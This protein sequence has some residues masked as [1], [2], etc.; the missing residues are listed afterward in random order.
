MTGV[1]VVIILRKKHVILFLLVTQA[2]LVLATAFQRSVFLRKIVTTI[3][4]NLLLCNI[5]K[6]TILNLTTGG[7]IKLYYQMYFAFL[8][9]NTALIFT[10]LVL[11]ECSNKLSS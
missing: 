3:A 11:S 10:S 7:Y 8:C 1:I 4:V 6:D 9:L 2:S 5:F